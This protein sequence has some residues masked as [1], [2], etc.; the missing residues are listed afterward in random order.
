MPVRL[1]LVEQ[2][3]DVQGSLD[4]FNRD[5]LENRD[6]ARDLL[7]STTY[8]V[9][10]PS[11]RCFGPSKFVGFKSMNFTDYAR[12]RGG[13]HEGARFNGTVARKAIERIL[14]L[15]RPDTRLSAELIRWGQAL[16]GSNVFD[17]ITKEKWK[18]VCIASLPEIMESAGGGPV[19][20]E[21]ARALTPGEPGE[22]T[23]RQRH[24]I[25]RTVR[26]E[27]WRRDS[28]KCARCGSRK[29]LE[30]DHIIP[31]SKGG[32]N[33]ARNIELLCE[34]CNREKGAKI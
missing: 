26:R 24:S 7:R 8:W 14:R 21:P 4:T 2:V 28:G 18:F 3:E 32:S 1:I 33:T 6:L 25:P 34:Q 31:V 11:T 19:A 10:S 17:G 5:F 22:E 23:S 29:N 13:D 20:S 9:Y 15:Y 12:A 30:F 16:L 27:V